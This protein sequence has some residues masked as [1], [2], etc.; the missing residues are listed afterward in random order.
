[1][2][3]ETR[4]VEALKWIDQYGEADIDLAASLFVYTDHELVYLF[5]GSLTEFN[6]FYAPV[7]LQ[8][9]AMRKAL[10]KNIP[11]YNLLGIRGEFDGSDGVLRFKQNFN[12]SI[13]RKMGTF[14][15]YPNPIKFKALQLLKKLLRK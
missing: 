1:M 10:D 3:F 14:R 11:F 7:A 6:A 8:E 12:G 9:F 15:Y 13:L 5:S 4:K 2:S